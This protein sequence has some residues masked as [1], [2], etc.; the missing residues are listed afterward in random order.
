MALKA[1]NFGL[2]IKSQNGGR[3]DEWVHC[4]PNQL[5]GM[6]ASEWG[7]VNV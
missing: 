2:K 5:C 4:W 1:E 6:M 3:T 7:R